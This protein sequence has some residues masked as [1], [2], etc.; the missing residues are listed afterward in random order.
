MVTI[1]IHIHNVTSKI[2]QKCYL[3]TLHDVEFSAGHT[4]IG[5]IEQWAWHRE[6][7]LGESRDDSILPV[8]SVGPG[9]Q[10]TRGTTTKDILLS[11]SRAEVISWVRLA[12]SESKASQFYTQLECLDLQHIKGAVARKRKQ[13]KFE[14]HNEGV[15]ETIMRAMCM[16]IVR[17]CIV[18][19]TFQI[20]HTQKHSR[21]RVIIAYQ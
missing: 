8:N 13:F 7:D 3:Y 4:R 6:V 21:A 20:T 18:E 2:I 10:L 16:R 5:A 14:L 17:V 12:I 11:S 1:Q 19:V 15:S 9:E